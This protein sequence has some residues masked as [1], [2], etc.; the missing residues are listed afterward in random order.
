MNIDS[1]ALD[2]IL[3]DID[4]LIMK[5]AKKVKE[6]KEKPFS[7][8]VNGE[9]YFKE[10]ELANDYGGGFITRKQYETG[11]KAFENHKANQDIQTINTEINY[12][13]QIWESLSDKKRELNG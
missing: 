9:E 1:K 5:R 8:I 6:L 12:L 11:L 2:S 7:V 3:N 10:H 13:T 4:K